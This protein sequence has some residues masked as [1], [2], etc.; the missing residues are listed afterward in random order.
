MKQSLTQTVQENRYL[1]LCTLLTREGVAYRTL[2]HEQ[3][4]TSDQSARARGE[5]VRIGGKAL[6]MK[7]GEDFRL[8]V[9]S[10]AGKIDS[11]P[12]KAHFNVKKSRFASPEELLRLTGLVPGSIPPFGKPLL[13]FAVFVDPSILDNERIAFNA[14]SL[15]DS[16]IMSVDDYLRIA[17]PTVFAFSSASL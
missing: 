5:D 4:F 2:R 15:T 8:F 7:V 12:I 10:A 13:P 9:L 11:S 17:R 1:A 16:I 3:T 14:G 6:V